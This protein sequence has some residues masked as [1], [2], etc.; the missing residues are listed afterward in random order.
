MEYNEQ[1]DIKLQTLDQI[2]EFTKGV[3]LIMALDSNA[4]STTWHDT[5]TTGA[6]LWKTLSPETS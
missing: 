3:K 6:K 1:I 4:R 2:T 5:T